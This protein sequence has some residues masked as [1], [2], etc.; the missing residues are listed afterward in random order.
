MN[1]YFLSLIMPAKNVESY[2]AQAIESYISHDQNDIILVI[3]DDNSTDNTYLICEEFE[4]KYPLKI[5]L[6][7]NHGSGKVNAINFGFTLVESEY[8]KFV[9]ADDVLEKSYW[10]L[11]NKNAQNK[12]SFVH[13]FTTVDKNLNKIT[14]LPMP[15]QSIKNNRKYL[16]NLIL[17]PKVAWT[18]NNEDIKTLFPIPEKMPFEDI[19][20]SFYIYSLNVSVNN[21]IESAY[22]YRQ[23]ENQTYGNI[24][25]IN[26]NRTLF[27]YKRIYKAIKI[28]EDNEIFK[29]LKSELLSAK[30][31]SLFMLRKVTFLMLIS[32]SGTL[33]SIKHLLLR[34]YKF[35][36]EHVR[37]FIWKI[38]TLV[39]VF[40]KL[41]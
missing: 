24:S 2:V 4:K 10:R 22:Y 3:I 11:L 35:I 8:Y 28:M 12:S 34:D 13:P 27:R 7:R 40:S 29:N 30:V 15:Y 26:E 5:I 14:T 37:K 23:H 41:R 32:K 38:R 9:D 18:F 36:Y 1:K 39:T 19:W 31:I 33:I 21:E 17:L 25:N 6:R 20:F 16:K